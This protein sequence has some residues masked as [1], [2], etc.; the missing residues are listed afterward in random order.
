MKK[1]RTTGEQ[2]TRCNVVAAALV[3]TVFVVAPLLLCCTPASAETRGYVISWFATATNTPDFKSNC[4]QNK[5]GGQVNL[6]IRNLVSIGYSKEDATKMVNKV[7]G[8]EVANADRSIRRKIVMRGNV[9]G[10]PASIYNY[11]DTVADPNIETVTGKYAYGFDLGG[12]LPA[13]KFEDPETHSKVDNQLWRAVGCTESFDAVP[14]VMPYPE[15]LAWQAM[16]DSAPAWL[17]QVS[18]DDLNKDGKVTVTLDRATRHPE[19]DATGSILSGATYVIDPNPRSHNVLRGQI[20]SGV[21]TIEPSEIYL[22][23]EMPYYSEI[24][25]RNTHMRMKLQPDGKLLGYWGG[26]QDWKRW[27]Y[28]YTARS[29]NNADTMG[30]YHAVKKMAD[31]D[32]DPV[33]GQN[34]YISA[35]YRMQAVPAYLAQPDGKVL[36]TPVIGTTEVVAQQLPQNAAAPVAK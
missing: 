21:L 28:M 6:A 32:P 23:A 30:I 5:N 27:V 36:A 26:Y 7:G 35:T 4:P 12:S 2:V 3:R 17:I 34:R 20:V 33:T 14:P 15:E 25:L 19:R 31:S 11:P 22:E 13:A 8:M 18:G 10:Q 24:A 16:T 29:G 9:N 1:N